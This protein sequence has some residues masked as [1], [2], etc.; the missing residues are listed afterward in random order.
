MIEIAAKANTR[1]YT[2]SKICA[3]CPDAE[4]EYHMIEMAETANARD[5]TFGEMCNPCPGPE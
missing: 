4:K 1:D 3:P 5:C 2:F